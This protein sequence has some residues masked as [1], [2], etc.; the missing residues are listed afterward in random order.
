MQ[1]SVNAIIQS[2]GSIWMPQ[3]ADL[4]FCKV[5][6]LVCTLGDEQSLYECTP[7]R[8]LQIHFLHRLKM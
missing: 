6:S 5:A 4:N 3:M 1:I 2:L 8:G 7:H